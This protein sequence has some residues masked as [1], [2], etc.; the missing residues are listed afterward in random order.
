[1]ISGRESSRFI[2]GKTTREAERLLRQLASAIAEPQY[3]SSKKSDM[4]IAAGL[5]GLAAIVEGCATQQGNI[6]IETNGAV[7]RNGYAA[8]HFIYPPGAPRIET[9]WMDMTSGPVRLKSPHPGLDISGRIGDS[10]L[11]AADGEVV[12]VGSNYN[13][14]KIIQ[15][16]HG[17]DKDG[18]HVLSGYVHLNKQLVKVGQI[19]K[20]GEQ[21][22]ELGMTGHNP[23]N[24]HLHF[25]LT[26][27]EE[28]YKPGMRTDPKKYFPQVNGGENGAVKYLIVCFDPS[29]KYNFPDITFTYPVK[30]DSSSI[31]V[32]K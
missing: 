2:E 19:V 7:I 29:A 31:Q 30:C 25:D 10:V 21:I 28:K 8:G 32:A 23:V 11:A 18:K 5:T 16:W 3:T 13:G 1:M 14:G 12:D 9:D 4:M 20:R 24:P 17:T 26:V 27:R 15:V 6:S 22:G